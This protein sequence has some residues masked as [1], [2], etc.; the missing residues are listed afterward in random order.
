M[1]RERLIDFYDKGIVTI[2]GLISHGRA[3]AF[4]Y[5]LGE[6]TQKFAL[7]SEKAALDKIILSKRP[8][9]SVNGNVAAIAGEEI[10]NFAKKYEIRVEANLFHWSWERIEK[11]VSMFEQFDLAILGRNQKERIP[12]IDSPRGKCER[13]GIFLA[14]T[15]VIPLEDGDRAE[16]L[17]RMGKFIITIDLNPLSR[18]SKSGDISIV[19]DLQRAFANFLKFERKDFNGKFAKYDNMMNLK[20]TLKFIGERLKSIE[21]WPQE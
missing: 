21:K 7:E 19:D 1:K 5:L 3:E 13:E 18:T 6:K 14:D 9:I 11:I 16:A 2:S 20:E 12:G 15:V 17:K 10:A 8:V 4:D